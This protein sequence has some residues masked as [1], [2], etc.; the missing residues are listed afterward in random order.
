VWVLRDRPADV[1]LR[2]YGADAEWREPDIVAASS[3]GQAAAGAVS[4]LRQV[5]TTRAFLLLAGTFFICGWTTNGIISTHFVPAAHDHGMTATTAAGLLAVVGIFDIIGTVGSGWLTDRMDP[6]VLLLA[7]YS[8]RGL[9]L[10]AVPAILG[11]EVEPPLVLVVILFGL[12]WV[13]T[14]PPTVTLCRENFGVELGGIVFGWIFAAHMV[15][16]GVAA[17]A[18]GALRSAQGDYVLAWLLAGGLAL[19][20]GVASTAVPRPATE[21]RVTA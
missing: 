2:P 4:A 20:A 8:L 15:G 13:A 19:A 7:Y 12:D 9:A 17:I 10:L 11:P 1:G 18:S 16:G 14:V 21:A 6:R 5:W 3:A